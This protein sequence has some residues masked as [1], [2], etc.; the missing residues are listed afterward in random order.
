[1]DAAYVPVVRKVNEDGTSSF[2]DPT[3]KLRAYMWEDH[4]QEGTLEQLFQKSVSVDLEDWESIWWFGDYGTTVDRVHLEAHII[5]N[6]QVLK[7]NYQCVKST[8]TDGLTWLGNKE[9]FKKLSG[10]TKLHL[11]FLDAKGFKLINDTYGQE[12]W[13]EAIAFI[14][15]GIKS[16]ISTRA[17]DYMIRLGGDEFVITFDATTTNSEKAVERALESIELYFQTHPFIAKVRKSDGTIWTEDVYIS[18]RAHA[19]YADG[20]HTLWE[21]MAKSSLILSDKSGWAV[22]KSARRLTEMAR[23]SWMNEE[24]F[25]KILVQAWHGKETLPV[26]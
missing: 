16:A 25:L 18:L 12:V 14:G 20:K 24:E 7:A 15:Q 22:M 26:E 6:H 5:A 3:G 2:S 11:S 23:K 4:P 1:M 19:E 8:Y 9:L 10:S 21:M 13:D 17:W